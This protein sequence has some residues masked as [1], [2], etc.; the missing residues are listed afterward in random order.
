MKSVVRLPERR[1]TLFDRRGDPLGVKIDS[2]KGGEVTVHS[3]CEREL[4]CALSAEEVSALISLLAP[5][6][7]ADAQAVSE[8]DDVRA[9]LLLSAVA[10]LRGSLEAA[11]TKAIAGP[12]QAEAPGTTIIQSTNDER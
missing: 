9:H 2:V 3:S 4:S 5:F 1:A 8:D 11:R 12:S 10:K 7:W 6:G